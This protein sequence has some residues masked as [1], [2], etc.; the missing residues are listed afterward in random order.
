MT[1][2]YL[3]QNSPTPPWPALPFEAWQGTCETLHLWMQI[4]GK[5]RLSQMPWI[6]H[7]WHVT[8]YVTA[9]GMTTMPMPYG[10]QTFQIDLDFIDHRLN[11]LA[12]DGATRAIA[13]RPMTVAAFYREVFA[14]PGDMGMDIRINAIPNELVDPIPF[15]QDEIH[16][17]YDPVFAN[18]FWRVLA[19]TERVFQQF[20]SGFG[21]KVSPIQFFWGSFD[22]AITRFSS[23]RAPEH[24]G[25]IPNLPDWI[26]RE[27]YSHEV[28]SA[29]FWPGN[30][31]YPVPFFY[32]YAYPEPEGFNQ[33]AVEP[34]E[35][36]YSDHFREF[37]LPYDAVR[38]AAD[39]DRAL[40]AFLQS[41]YDAAADLGEWERDELDC[42][43]PLPQARS[44]R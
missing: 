36:H 38:A 8:L 13:L 31:Q 35:A 32:S 3:M 11:I 29:G 41:T 30:A 20:R 37:I 39:P 21:G 27:A 4:I 6:N 2:S 34:G 9:R 25:G 1:E 19:Q 15:E 42:R 40:L 26:T 43:L 44:D 12:S 16:N 7:S 18:R 23:K 28:S 5:I 17:S 14:A 10:S 22:L 24:P 33:A